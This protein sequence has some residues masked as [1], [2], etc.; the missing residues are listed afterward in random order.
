MVPSRTLHEWMKEDVDVMRY[1]RWF[2]GSVSSSASSAADAVVGACCGADCAVVDAIKF[3]F[4][5]SYN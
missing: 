5:T 1:I 4:C 3:A 2:S